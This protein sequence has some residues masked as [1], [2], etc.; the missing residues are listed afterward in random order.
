[1]PA[2]YYKCMNCWE[3]Q[4]CG[5]EP[6]GEKVT[7]LGLCPAAYNEKYNG[8]N[9]GLNAGRYCWRAAGT[10]S[11]SNICPMS[12]NLLSCAQCDFYHLVRSEEGDRFV[13]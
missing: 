4:K 12:E 5:R 2:I 13:V 6:G 10:L 9:N 7:S 3:F 11:R 1:M 8:Y